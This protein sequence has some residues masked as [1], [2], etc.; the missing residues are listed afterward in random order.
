MIYFIKIIAFISMFNLVAGCVS[1]IPPDI[2]DQ[3]SKDFGSNE[4]CVKMFSA[5]PAECR[6]Y[7][8]VCRDYNFVKNIVGY[9]EPA[10]DARLASF[11]VARDDNGVVQMCTWNFAGFLRG[12]DYLNNSV[13]SQCEQFRLTYM[14][15]N[16]KALQACEVYA[17][18]N[19]IL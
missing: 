3:I 15:K 4:H 1:V 11:V 17:H 19:D 6:N 10:Q 9:Q 8:S 16:Q 18:D 14:S 12:R 7:P 13:L 5:T 2:K